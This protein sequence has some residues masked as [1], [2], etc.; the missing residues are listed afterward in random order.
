MPIR[1]IH[2]RGYGQSWRQG[3]WLKAHAAS[4]ADFTSIS[5]LLLCRQGLPD[6]RHQQAD[7]ELSLASVRMQEAKQAAETANNAKSL[8]AADAALGWIPAFA[9]MTIKKGFLGQST[10]AL[11]G[12]RSK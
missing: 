12:K 1:P 7:I 5:T 9:G 10:S 11:T 2:H 8:V 6:R 4:Y 3:S